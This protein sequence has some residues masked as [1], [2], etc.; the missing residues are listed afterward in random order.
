M[1]QAKTDQRRQDVLAAYKGWCQHGNCR[2]LWFLQTGLKTYQLPRIASSKPQQTTTQISS[3]VIKRRRA[4]FARL[5][6]CEN[7]MISAINHARLSYYTD[8]V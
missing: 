4:Y 5:D 6:E 3:H 2:R 7:I 1:K 8:I